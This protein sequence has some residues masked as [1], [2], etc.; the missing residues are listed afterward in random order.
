MQHV[1]L[2]AFKVRGYYHDRESNQ[3][4]VNQ[5]VVCHED[6]G[7]YVLHHVIEWIKVQFPLEGKTFHLYSITE[8]PP[9]VVID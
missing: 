1:Q 2:F 9:P 5:L 6:E 8:T 3:I 7:P 4:N